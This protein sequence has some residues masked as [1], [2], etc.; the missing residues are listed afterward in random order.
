[1]IFLLF[2]FSFSAIPQDF[3]PIELNDDRINQSAIPFL[4]DH[5]S[6]LFPELNLNL[7]SFNITAAGILIT[8][9]Y[10]L[11]LEINVTKNL[12]FSLKLWV[13]SRMVA[14][15]TDIQPII[16]NSDDLSSFKWLDPSHFRVK[17]QKD[18]VSLIEQF[19]N[20]KIHI[21]RILI[22]RKKDYSGTKEHIIFQDSNGI[23]NSVV[24]SY[25]PSTDSTMIEF[26]DSIHQLKL[27][28]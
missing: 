5:L 20:V 24:T 16:T 26:Y 10:T 15:L 21:L 7:N 17:Q 22:Y 13:S 4:N 9:G 3:T 11:Y 18:L 12:C 27:P 8:S 28:N 14:Q 23:I 2:H 25:S 19:R 1:M 6:T